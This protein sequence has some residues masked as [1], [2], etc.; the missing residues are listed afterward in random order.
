MFNEE[1][2]ARRSVEAILEVLDAIPGARLIVVDDGSSDGTRVVLQ[3]IEDQEQ[4]FDLVIREVNGGY[5]AAL[6]AGAAWADARG[7]AWVLFMD[8]D[9]TNPPEDV[10]LFAEVCRSDLYDLVK[11]SR[12]IEGGDMSGVPIARRLFSVGGNL[13]FRVAIRSEVRDVTNGFRAIRLR[14]LRDMPLRERDFLVIVEEMYHARRL[15]L[16]VTEIP[17]TLRSRTADQGRSVF[18][19]S[20]RVLIRY[21]VWASRIL[22]VRGPEGF[23][24]PPR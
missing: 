10:D 22:L 17:S 24:V 16:R 6:A 20:L 5:G 2:H 19:Y 13:V 4:R 3:E 7:F 18:S 12:F 15:G 14:A 9:L 1:S 11:A 23:T 21:L 8:S